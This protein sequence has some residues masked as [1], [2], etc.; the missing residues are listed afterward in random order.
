MPRS[1]TYLFSVDVED[2]RL[3]VP[4]GEQYRPRVEPMT[5]RYLDWLDRYGFSATFFVVGDIAR[6]HPNLV[7]EI[8]ERGHELGC[9]SNRHVPLDQQTPSEFREDLVAC[10]D[11]LAA[12]GA[13]R[14]IGYR[15]P[16]FSLTQ[17]TEWAYDILAAHGIAYSS[18][19]LPAPNPL[20][21]WP[22]FGTRARR[23]PSG[24]LEI[25]MTLGRVGPLRV[26]IG[27]GVY[28]RALPFKLIE[29]VMQRGTADV[30]VTGYFHPYDI[31][32]EQERFMHAGI[33]N[34]RFYHWLMFVGRGAVLPRLDK[35]VEK[36]HRVETYARY[37]ERFTA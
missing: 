20:Y 35:L 10:L 5:R 32:E 8:A 9:H 18:S 13:R 14:V 11:A 27:G 16:T 21:G 24:V 23:M 37:A 22:E 17:R 2:A 3:M 4:N 31:D 15:A 25:P 28:F 26:P 12:C 19:V 6:R 7:R 1:R 29:W 33:N 30:P 36:G 34:N